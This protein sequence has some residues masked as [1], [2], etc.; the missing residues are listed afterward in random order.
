MAGYLNDVI[1]ISYMETELFRAYKPLFKCMM[2]FGLYHKNRKCAYKMQNES[3]E[4]TESAKGK[5]IFKTKCN[6][7]KNWSFSQCYCIFM[8]CFM[9]LNAVR[10][11][12][13]IDG[14]ESFGFV[15]FL[16]IIYIGWWL[17]L[18]VNV[19]VC[20]SAFSNNNKIPAFFLEWHWLQV[21]YP[22]STRDNHVKVML[23]VLCCLLIGI[24]CNMG[25]ISYSIFE[26]VFMDDYI[27][28]PYKGE[29]ESNVLD[30]V[31]RLYAICPLFFG[32]M[33][34]LIPV[35]LL[36]IVCKYY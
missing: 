11:F 21:N 34:W 27:S 33:A 23:I 15:L 5:F 13:L 7:T 25:L 2:I 6:F 17:K 9:A 30:F 12:T 18:T 36:Y 26:T 16:R 4:T 29:V 20:Y 8:L 32:S 22:P 1:S 19:Y 24:F 10:S 31:L 35:A 14:K 28:A 3:Q